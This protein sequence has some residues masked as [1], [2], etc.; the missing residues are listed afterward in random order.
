MIMGNPKFWAWQQQVKNA[1][2][3]GHQLRTGQKAER[4]GRLM[5]ALAMVVSK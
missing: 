2:P 3:R 4:L 5:S 1:L